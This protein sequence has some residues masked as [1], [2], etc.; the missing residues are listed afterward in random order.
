M[1]GYYKGQRN[2]GQGQIPF[3][4]GISLTKPGWL[5]VKIGNQTELYDS[6]GG[7]L[8]KDSS[9]IVTSYS[10][11]ALFAGLNKPWMGLHSIDSVRRDAAAVAIPFQ[12]LLLSDADKSKV[13]L[14]LKEGKIEYLLNMEQD[15]IEKIAFLDASGNACGEILL[16]TRR[17]DRQGAIS[18]CRHHCRALKSR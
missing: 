4:Y 17:P 2:T 15:W 7:A 9:G 1:T 13:T 18:R 12:T 8:K 16:I 5:S 3:Y 14:L 6:V 11:N 10:P